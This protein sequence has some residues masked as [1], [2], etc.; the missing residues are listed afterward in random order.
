MTNPQ[1]LEAFGHHMM[2]LEILAEAISSGELTQWRG[3]KAKEIIVNA[4]A[5]GVIKFENMSPQELQSTFD[6][7]ADVA[8]NVAAA[9]DLESSLHTE[10]LLYWRHEQSGKLKEPVEKFI[11][12]QEPLTDNERELLANYLWLW[13]S[14]PSWMAPAEGLKALKNSFESMVKNGDRASIE[15]W[16]ENLEELGL[17]DPW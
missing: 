15:Q 1:M 5:Q 6:N 2:A 11:C 17:A 8:N 10:P 9:I 14:H 12:T 7:F 3:K 13:V 4:L 16:C